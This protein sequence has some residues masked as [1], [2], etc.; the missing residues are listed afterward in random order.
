LVSGNRLPS[1]EPEG[2]D[3]GR[4]IEGGSLTIEGA[5]QLVGVSTKTIRRAI[6]TG[7]LKAAKVAGRHGGYRIDRADLLAVW[8]EPAAKE[9]PRSPISEV[10]GEISAMREAIEA[11]RRENEQLRAEVRDSRGQ[12]HQLQETILKALPAPQSPPGLSFWDRIT[13]RGTKGKQ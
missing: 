4:M 2:R 6:S 8:P 11:L 13:G 9:A 5:A 1:S 7:K 12:I 10:A 3:G